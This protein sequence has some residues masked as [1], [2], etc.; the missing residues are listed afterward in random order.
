M[1]SKANTACAGCLRNVRRQT[2]QL[3]VSRFGASSHRAFTTTFGRYAEPHTPGAMPS[4]SIPLVS[5]TRVDGNLKSKSAIPVS[6]KA[7]AGLQKVTGKATETYTAYGATE[8]LYKECARQAD[9]SITQEP[10]SEEEMPKTED[11][12]DL[13]VGDGWWLQE[14]GLKPTFSTWSQVT[15]LHMYLLSVRIR[16]FPAPSHNTWQQHLLDHFFHD[17]ENRMTIYHNMHASGTRSKYLKDLFIQWR[18]L[19][20]AYDEGLVKGDAVLAAAVWRNVFKANEDVDI[21]ALGQI[22]SYMRR[23]LKGLDSLPDE[24]ISQATLKFGSPEVESAIVQQQSRLMDL[25]FEK[26]SGKDLPGGKQ[27]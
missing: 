12:E 7:A 13:G 23:A 3:Q 24:R 16:C 2:P 14:A 9:Y 20:A 22:V 5:K 27:L 21:R 19:L 11:G 26:A 4:S 18:G 25:P 17:A 8:N 1:A 6:M 15:M 10:N